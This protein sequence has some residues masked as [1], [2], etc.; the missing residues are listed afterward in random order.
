MR[1]CATVSAYYAPI[2]YAW[3]LRS[4]FATLQNSRLAPVDDPAGVSGKVHACRTTAQKETA[5]LKA[6]IAAQRSAE[7]KTAEDTGNLARAFLR[8]DAVFNG[9][10]PA[11]IY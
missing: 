11:Y 1:S 8:W 4:L 7:A 2:I 10:F 3:D 9:R 5:L 6:G